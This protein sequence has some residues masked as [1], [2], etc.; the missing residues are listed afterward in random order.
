ML[1]KILGLTAE[2]IETS[3]FERMFV[4]ILQQYLDAVDACTLLDQL[5][6]GH[7]RQGPPKGVP[8]EQVAA[9]ETN[10]QMTNEEWV[11]RLANLTAQGRAGL[12]RTFEMMN[13]ALLVTQGSVSLTADEMK[14]RTE[15]G[16]ATVSQIR[17][18]PA[19]QEALRLEAERKH[20]E[21]EAG[22][23]VE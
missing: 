19:V 10:L 23:S 3:G 16:V 12:L 6:A 7:Q 22:P 4:Q 1:Q 18:E 8:P 9:M 14:A 13:E 17:A 2:V 15:E 20:H 21:G 11:L 5:R